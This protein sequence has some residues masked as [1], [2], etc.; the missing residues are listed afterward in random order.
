MLSLTW[1]FKKGHIVI[2]LFVSWVIKRCTQFKLANKTNKNGTKWNVPKIDQYSLVRPINQIWNLSDSSTF[3]QKTSGLNIRNAHGVEKDKVEN[4]NNIRKDDNA[5]EK[6]I[7]CL[8]L[9]T[10]NDKKK[11]ETTLN[12]ALNKFVFF[13]FFVS[14]PFSSLGRNNPVLTKS[15]CSFYVCLFVCLF[16]K[17]ERKL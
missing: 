3:G 15:Y 13:V 6:E 11:K 7:T 2:F 10:N 4:L 1:L 5:C 17:F 8:T 14:S 9:L 12:S 16:R